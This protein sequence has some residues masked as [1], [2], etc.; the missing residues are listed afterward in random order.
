MNKILELKLLSLLGSIASFNDKGIHW[1][2]C[3]DEAKK[4]QRDQFQEKL[5]GFLESFGEKNLT[6]E[7]LVILKEK[8]TVLDFTGESEETIKYLMKNGR[9]YS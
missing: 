7:A 5:E 1:M 2:K 3:D 6:S 4:S 9:F 8:G